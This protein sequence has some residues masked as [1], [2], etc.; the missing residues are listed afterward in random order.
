M[1]EKQNENWKVVRNRT[2]IRALLI[3]LGVIFMQVLGYMLCMVVMTVLASVQSK[4][5]R[6][7]EMIARAND[8]DGEF[9]L[10]VSL[11][12][13][14][15]SLIWCGILYGRSQW[16][17]KNF[18]YRKIL[19]MKNIGAVVGI[20]AG[21][22]IVLT[23]VLTGIQNLIPQAFGSYNQVMNDLTG[24]SI[25]LTVLYVLLVGPMAEEFIFRGAILDRFYLA[26]PFVIAN[27]LQALLFGIYHMNL[28]QG[29]YAF[30][31][32]SILGIIRHK[33]GSIWFCVG[34]HMLFNTMSFVLDAVF[35]Q[36][37]GTSLA[38]LILLT[39]LGLLGFVW[40]MK[41][42]LKEDSKS[43]RI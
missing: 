1:I 18:D 37:T 27:G 36:K 23:V 5:Q 35:S 11:V 3:F 6:L 24:Q 43:Q 39:V 12:S 21:G 20:G 16:R 41:S 7:V 25:G 42:L 28:I 10:W 32:G 8:G 2:C 17:E 19:T 22:C 29:L 33:I 15:L 30:V 14:G 26:F 4:N 34:T 31:I 38:W 40:G 9:L 13:A